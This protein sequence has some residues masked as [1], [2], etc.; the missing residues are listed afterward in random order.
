MNI[1]RIVVPKGLKFAFLLS[2]AFF[3]ATAAPAQTEAEVQEA[4]AKGLI[5]FKA[6]N[7]AE[8]VPYL[9]KVVKAMPEDPD[10]RFMYG[11]SLVAKSKQ[12]TDQN[13]AK[14]LSAAAL[15]QLQTAKKLG[16]N[17][18]MLD[19]LIQLLGGAPAAG[20]ATTRKLSP[21]E[22]ALNQAEG[23]FARSN[24]DEAIVHY[25]KALALDPKLYEAALHAGD[26]Y[27]GKQ[28]WVNAEKYYQKAIA[29]DPER[30]TAYRYSGTPLMRQKKYDDARDRY[31]EAYI[32]EPYGGMSSRGISQ[33]AGATGAKLGH[34]KIK[35]PEA[36]ATP[37][38]KAEAGPAL[39]WNAYLTV[40]AEW[41]KTKF[42]KTFPAEKTYRH[43]LK[44]EAEAIRSALRTA[45][46]KKI[47]DADLKTLQKMEGDGVLESFI[48]LSEADE[49]IAA[50]HR[51]YW[52]EN[53]PSL[54]KYILNYVIAK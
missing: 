23:H 37:D 50:D 32:T 24:Y 40:R 17:E 1:L 3:A 33:W 48:L 54:R 5:L 34:P 6:E 25:D 41:R 12:T 52:K 22:E 10:L 38:E 11:W 47:E 46:D 8:A 42:A 30:E 16:M 18:P 21:A 20:A 45:A 49:G 39:A 28:D 31:V 26:S 53:R 35:F 27:V 44:E 7:Y 4:L 43:S 9:E 14:K 19:S 15:E 36:N 2:I 51:A 13:E 29:I